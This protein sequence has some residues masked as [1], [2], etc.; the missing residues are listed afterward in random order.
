MFDLSHKCYNS[1]LDPNLA[2]SFCVQKV[3]DLCPIVCD[4]HLNDVIQHLKGA[5]NVNAKLDIILDFCEGYN[6]GI[7]YLKGDFS[8]LQIIKYG[9][10][11]TF[12]AALYRCDIYQA[13]V[14]T[15][16]KDKTFPW[17]DSLFFI[18]A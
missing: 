10:L 16:L 9:Q 8:A 1:R 18:K 14:N 17:D 13:G 7:R 11:T 4:T 15:A 2:P 3:D 5:P 6:D 12:R